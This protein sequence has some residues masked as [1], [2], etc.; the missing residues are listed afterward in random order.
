MREHLSDHSNRETSTWFWNDSWEPVLVYAL[1]VCNTRVW[2]QLSWMV[3]AWVSLQIT[4][5]T[6]AAKGCSFRSIG[7]ITCKRAFEVETTAPRE[8][9]AHSP[10]LVHTDQQARAQVCTSDRRFRPA[11]YELSNLYTQHAA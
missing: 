7:Q 5:Q 10:V 1:H 4:L 3:L 9:T 11:H 2:E 6:T 8:E